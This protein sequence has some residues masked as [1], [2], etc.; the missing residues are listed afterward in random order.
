MSFRTIEL[1]IDG[2]GVATLRLNR[3]DKH[4][5]LS[6]EL[7]EDLAAAAARLGSDP[8]VRVVVLEAAGRSFCAG[9]DLAWMRAQ[10][11][12]DRATRI[13]EARRLADMLH[14]V[15]T[16]DKPLVARVHGAAYGG[17]V[18]LMSI[19]DVVVASL[20]ARFGLTETRLGVIPAT[21]SPY[22]VARIG[23]GAA[24]SLIL[25]GRLFDAEEA[26]LVGLATRVERQDSLDRAV[27]AAVEAYL[28][29]SPAAVAAAKRLIR[30]LGPR[31]DAETIAWTVERLADTWETPEAQAGV[32]AFLE[33]SSPPWAD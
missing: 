12:A 27:A 1:G 6:A 18:G 24:R 11:D 7:V 5:A 14:A 32:R 21:I 23:E 2:R 9:G 20:D 22:V 4:N 8:D 26:R 33:R 15:N 16:L 25:S 28:A 29:A 31:I 30:A 19:C 3:P 13:S 10:F 17:G